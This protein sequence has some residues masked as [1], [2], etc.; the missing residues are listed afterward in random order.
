MCDEN[1]LYKMKP[2]QLKP[3]PVCCTQSSKCWCNDLS[4]RFPMDQIQD[5]CMSPKQMLEYYGSE[6]SSRD[7][8]YLQSLLGRDFISL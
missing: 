7:K 2:L 3:K 8:K 5:E 4:F 1:L 6:M